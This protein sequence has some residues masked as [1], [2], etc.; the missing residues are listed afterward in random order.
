MKVAVE[1]INEVGDI[2]YKYGEYGYGQQF[3]INRY[4]QMNSFSANVQWLG[5]VCGSQARVE[6]GIQ[7]L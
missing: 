3:K 1:V 4:K 5:E 6:G 7:S 2:R